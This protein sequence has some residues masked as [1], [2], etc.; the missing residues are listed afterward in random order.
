[1][2]ETYRECRTLI[3]T[4][5]LGTRNVISAMTQSQFVPLGQGQQQPPALVSA[6]PMS[7]AQL[8]EEAT[9]FSK[10]FKNIT[11]CM[12]IF[13]VPPSLS[14]AEE[15]ELFEAYFALFTSPDPRIF[16]EVMSN[17]MD[18]YFH[19]IA[20]NQML[21]YTAQLFISSPHSHRF[22]A[23]TLVNYLMNRLKYASLLTALSCFA[24]TKS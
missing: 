23:E 1:L 18:F 10:L 14:P 13:T 7:K 11:R 4:L 16:Q 6:G 21:L 8:V 24:N 3:R 12:S 19:S 15:K 2:P 17:H 22:F 5:I 9:I 20:D